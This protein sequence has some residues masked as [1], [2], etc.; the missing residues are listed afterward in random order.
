MAHLQYLIFDGENVPMPTSYSLM[1]TDVKAESIGTTEAGTMQR[2][3]VREGVLEIRVS[4]QVSKKWL[5][6]LSSFKKQ[7][8]ITVG[9]LNTETM[10]RAA[11]EMYIE[12]FQCALAAD[13]SYGSLGEVSF[14]LKEF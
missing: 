9:Y 5:M 13:T 8:K 12:G 14:A 11:A 1:K 6:K 2:D 3:V 7:T 10:E 4:F